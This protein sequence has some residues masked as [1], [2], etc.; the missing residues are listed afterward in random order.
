MA[1]TEEN[2]DVPIPVVIRSGI[3]QVLSGHI[4]IQSGSIGAR[5]SGAVQVSG[6]VGISGQVSIHSGHI[7]I[8]SGKIAAQVSGTV[9]ISGQVGVQSGHISIQSGK[10]SISSGEVHVLSGQLIAKVSGDTVIAVIRDSSGTCLNI[11]DVDGAAIE[12]THSHHEIHEGNTY[13]VSAYDA[14]SDETSGDN[15]VWLVY[16]LQLS[17]VVH[18]VYSIEADSEVLLR[19]AETPTVVTTGS[20]LFA[21]N[22]D[23]RSANSSEV[24]FYTAS[25]IGSGTGTT[26][27]YIK[28]GSTGG[29]QSVA[30]G[31]AEHDE[32][33]ILKTSGVYS[34]EAIPTS[35]GTEVVLNLSYYE[36][37]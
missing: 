32:E 1:I 33:F 23:R 20:V 34:F 37:R 28:L 21:H 29:G 27:D 4:S 5:V 10:V 14:D 31:G 12:I 9:A 30:G 22:K 18:L 17:T 25:M 13:H 15:S 19:F 26:L 3:V 24:I 8:Q 11:D 7:S 36:V 16:P 6:I 35:A 2:V